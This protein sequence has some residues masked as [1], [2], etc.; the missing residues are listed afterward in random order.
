MASANENVCL[1]GADPSKMSTKEQLKAF[2]EG[3][4]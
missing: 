2:I 3:E 4:C 1:G